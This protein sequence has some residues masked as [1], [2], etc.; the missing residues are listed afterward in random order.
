MVNRQAG[1]GGG[2]SRLA[3][4][5]NLHLTGTYRNRSAADR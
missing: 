2:G 5:S 4:T 3:A 1:G